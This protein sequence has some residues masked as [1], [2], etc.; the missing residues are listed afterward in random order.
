MKICFIVPPNPT[1]LEDRIDPHLGVLSVAAVVRERGH[2]VDYIEWDLA[3]GLGDFPAADIYGITAYGINYRTATHIAAL[4]KLVYPESTTVIG[5]PVA[6]DLPQRCL[7]DFDVVCIHEG[8]GAFLEFLERRETGRFYFGSCPSYTLGTTPPPAYDLVD[9]SKYSR[10]VMGQRAF[11]L[12]TSRGCLYN[13]AFCRNDRSWGRVQIQPDRAVIRDIRYCKDVTGFHAMLFWDNVFELRVS[14]E[15]LDKLGQEDIIFS[16]QTRG[17]VH[18]WD[19]KIYDAGGRVVFIGLETGDPELLKRMKKGV[20]PD[21]LRAAVYEAQKV[22]V[23][24]RCGIL[25]GF[26][27]ETPMSLERTRKFVEDL[28]PD[29]TFLSFFAPFPGTDVWRNPAKYGVTWMR[30]WDQYQLQ[31]KKGWV[32]ASLET[33]WLS[34]DAWNQLAPEMAQWWKELPRNR[35]ADHSWWRE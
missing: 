34:R 10:L 8:E 12:M 29:Q 5:G 15:F 26:P 17:Q 21:Q 33:P 19:K 11:G 16:Y 31:G 24:V 20:T 2:E 1:A 28:K 7:E 22:G 27:G 14:D 18:N 35:E 30:P 32:E 23:N 6:S 13:C 25:F 9:W 3:A 4:C